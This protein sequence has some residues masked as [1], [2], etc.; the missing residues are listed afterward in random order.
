MSF[1]PELSSKLTTTVL[2]FYFCMAN[3]RL[4]A[5]INRLFL[6]EIFSGVFKKLSILSAESLFRIRF[7]RASCWVAIDVISVSA[8]GVVG[9][10]TEVAPRCEQ[11]QGEN[12]IE[13]FIISSKTPCFFIHGRPRIIG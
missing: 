7:G 13:L 9:T 8:A 6:S 1:L 10:G 3:F 12:K 4:E 11:Y 2:D 5:L